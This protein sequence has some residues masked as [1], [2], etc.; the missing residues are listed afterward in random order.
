MYQSN[1]TINPTRNVVRWTARV[2]SILFLAVFILMFLTQGFSL[3]ELTP[4]EWISLFFFPFGATLGMILAWWQEGLGG[5]ITVVSVFLSILVHDPSSGGGYM[6]AC[7]S[8]GLLFLFSWVLSLSTTDL[9]E[10]LPEQRRI[11]K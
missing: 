4:R 11:T 6:F 8:P 9:T 3:N 1:V 7:A 2:V 5:A 10:D